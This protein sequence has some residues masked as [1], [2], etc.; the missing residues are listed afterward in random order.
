MK[1][2]AVFAVVLVALLSA[3]GPSAAAQESYRVVVHKD[4]PIDS[5]TKQQLSQ[6]LLKKRSRWDHNNTSAEP[7]DLDSGSAVREMSKRSGARLYT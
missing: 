6:L 5:I 4:N 1:K 7:V 3:H 2:L